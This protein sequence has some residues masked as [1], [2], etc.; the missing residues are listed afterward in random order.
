[1]PA[2]KYTLART[3]AAWSYARELRAEK[4]A[5]IDAYRRLAAMDPPV[6][7]SLIVDLKRVSDESAASAARVGTRAAAIRARRNAERAAAAGAALDGV[8]A[9]TSATSRSR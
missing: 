5:H 1:M 4:D 6:L 2:A 3:Y 7:R 9:L 8:D